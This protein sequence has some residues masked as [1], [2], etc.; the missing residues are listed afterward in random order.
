VFEKKQFTQYNIGAMSSYLKVLILSGSIPFILSFWPPLKFYRNFK[1]LAFS[2]LIV[3]LIFGSWDVFATYRGHWY[4]NPE[5]VLGINII[6]LPLE[7]VLFFIVIPF[8][9]IFTWEA[10]KYL[11]HKTK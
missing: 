6:N 5:G 7:E 1:A 10:I 4:F 2:I 3:L 11:K 9:C 8:C